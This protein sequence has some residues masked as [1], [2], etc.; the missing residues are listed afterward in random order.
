MFRKKI[1]LIVGVAI[2]ATASVMAQPKNNCNGE[3]HKKNGQGKMQMLDN[4]GL[5]EEQEVKLVRLRR[6]MIP[7]RKKQ[8]ETMMAVRM[9]IKEELNKEKVNRKK[10]TELSREMA[11]LHFKR[12]EQMNEHMLKIRKVLTLEQFKK[13]GNRDKKGMKKNMHYTE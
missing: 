3:K 12:S 2:L 9:K 13:L 5:T 10:L 7:I 11:E 4:L 1:S 6:E 8:H